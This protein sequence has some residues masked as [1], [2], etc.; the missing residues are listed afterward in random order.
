MANSQSNWL[1]GEGPA[2]SGLGWEGRRKVLQ[3]GVSVNDS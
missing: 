1:A 3:E 2:G